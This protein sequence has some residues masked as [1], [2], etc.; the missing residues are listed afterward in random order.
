MRETNSISNRIRMEQLTDSVT[1]SS[2]YLNSEFWFKKNER[3]SSEKSR[4]KCYWIIS[5]FSQEVP[6]K[7]N[8]FWVTLFSYHCLW[9]N[10]YCVN[11]TSL[12]NYFIINIHL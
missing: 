2:Q 6:I 7:Y 12:L 3:Q 11:E 10:K 5:E 4:N 1:E 8:I 9:F